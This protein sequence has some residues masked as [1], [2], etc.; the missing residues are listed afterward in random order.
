MVKCKGQVRI[1]LDPADPGL[2]ACFSALTSRPAEAQ[3]ALSAWT[4]KLLEGWA[5][6]FPLQAGGRRKAARR[7]AVP[8]KAG[9]VWDIAELDSGLTA[10][11]GR[12][13]ALSNRCGEA[14][15]EELNRLGAALARESSS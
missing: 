13:V 1:H 5:R 10:K 3:Q 9:E 15:I 7:K 11:P 14:Q 8:R 4:A 2:E 12:L 6:R